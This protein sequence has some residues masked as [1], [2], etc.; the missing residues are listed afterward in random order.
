MMSSETAARRRAWE[1]E[2]AGPLWTAAVMD[3]FANAFPVF[4]VK[5]GPTWAAVTSVVEGTYEGGFVAIK[6]SDVL[7]AEYLTFVLELDWSDP[8][9]RRMVLVFPFSEYK[10]E[11]LMMV[12]NGGACA[13]A[14][15]P[16]S[17][18]DML[19]VGGV[20]TEIVLQAFAALLEVQ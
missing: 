2:S 4:G 14:T 6:E 7:M 13:L 16:G 10:A 12:K 11:L 19:M 20:P 18:E 3:P 9:D 8:P 15:K 1:N 17:I 5:P